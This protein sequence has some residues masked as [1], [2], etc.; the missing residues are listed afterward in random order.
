MLAFGIET[1]RKKG[2]TIINLSVDTKNEKALGL[3]KKFG[4]YTR[5]N[6][7]QKTYQI[8]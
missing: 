3:Y 6:F 4:F 5:D 2:C 7:T 1:L 8:I